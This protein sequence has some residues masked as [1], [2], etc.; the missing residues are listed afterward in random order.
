MPLSLSPLPISPPPSGSSSPY[1][2]PPDHTPLSPPPSLPSLEQDPPPKK[3]SHSSH[4]SLRL[5]N[6]PLILPTLYILEGTEKMLLGNLQGGA[7]GVGLE[8]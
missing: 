1:P 2:V 5:R 4:N 3:I 8:V 7:L 6:H